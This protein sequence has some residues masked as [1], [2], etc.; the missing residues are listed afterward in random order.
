[1]IEAADARPRER[2]AWPTASSCRS[3]PPGRRCATATSPGWRE[4]EAER[5]AFRRGG[6][7]QSSRSAASTLVG[8]LDRIDRLPTAAPSSST[9]RPRRSTRPP[10]PRQGPGRGHAAGLLCRA[11]GRRHACARPTSTSARRGGTQTVE[12][13]DVVAARDALV[14]GHHATTCSAS[15]RARAAGAGRGRGVRLLRRARPVPQGLLEPSSNERRAG[16]RAQRPAGRARGL[17]RHRL[18]S[19]AQV[20]VEACAGAGKTWMLVSRIVRALLDEG[21]APGAARDP[22][23][24]LHQEGR[25]RDARSGSTSG[26]TQFAGCSTPKRWRPSW[27]RAAW[28]PDAARQP[29]RR[30]CRALYRA[31]AATAAG[32]CSSAPS[33][34]VRRAAAQ[35][36]DG[37][38]GGAAACRRTTSCWKTTPRRVARVWRP[39]LRRGRAADAGARADYEAWSPAHGRSQTAKALDAALTQRV[40]FTLADAHGAVEAPVQPVRRAVSRAS[41]AL[42]RP[43]RRPG[44]LDAA[45]AGVGWTR[46][47][48]ARPR[49]DK[50]PQTLPPR[51]STRARRGRARR[52]PAWLPRC[53]AEAFLVKSPRTGSTSTWRKCRPRRRPRPSCRCCARRSAQHAAWLHQ[54]RMARLTRLLIDAFAAAQARARLGRHERRRARAAQLLLGDAGAVG[55]GAGAARR[56]RAR[57]C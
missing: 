24:H 7:A 12:Q 37:G 52:R 11:A 34:L 43:G 42:R 26:W 19:A 4:H 2:R 46:A 40:E 55:L 21:E 54:Q 36:A 14:D 51:A 17:L 1:M 20:A 10:R 13:P 33:T 41:P 32:R 15:P 3:P 16:L 29:P 28:Q 50:T 56:A 53:C 47:A 57:T 27:R 31:P 35:R 44:R 30:G 38:A 39:L 22:G 45:H 5:R 8:R 25:R 49:A 6:A 48:R 18:R 23:H 9:T